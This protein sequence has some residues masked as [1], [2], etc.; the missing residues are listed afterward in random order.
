MLR[1]ALLVV[2]LAN[3]L[4]GLGMTGVYFK[5]RSGGG[6]PV[7][8]LFIALALV[9]QGGFTIGHLQGWWKQWGTWAGQLFV[10]GESA[11]A[12]AGTIGTIQ[13][14]L[15]NLHPRNGDQE[16]G[17]LMVAILIG[18]QAALGLAYAARNGDVFRHVLNHPPGS[19]I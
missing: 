12:L 9:V 11:A 5:F 6:V 18:T 2:S 19:G 16:F 7:V 14:I 10:A 3:L 8:V 15:Y 17:P 4:T 13:G 1:I